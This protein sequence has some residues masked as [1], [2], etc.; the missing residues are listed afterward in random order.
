MLD[1]LWSST[2]TEHT[3]G[4]FPQLYKCLYPGTYQPLLIIV[5]R[6]AGGPEKLLNE[7]IV[8]LH[9][10]ILGKN[11]ELTGFTAHCGRKWQ[12]TSW[13]SKYCGRRAAQRA[14]CCHN[15]DSWSEWQLVMLQRY[16]CL[17][18]RNDKVSANWHGLLSC[19]AEL[20][21]NH[22]LFF[23]IDKAFWRLI[24]RRIAVLSDEGRFFHANEHHSGHSWWRGAQAQ[25]HRWFQFKQQ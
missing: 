23:I 20:D 11:F 16:N 4:F 3:G 17:C 9:L 22:G 25:R 15:S 14:S 19:F 7:V 18:F 10:Q 5:P 2:L 13:T 1:Q 21:P 6:N 24:P 12:I 8:P